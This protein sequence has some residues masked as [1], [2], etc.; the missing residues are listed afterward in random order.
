M[1]VCDPSISA[2]WVPQRNPKNLTFNN[3][4]SNARGDQWFNFPLMCGDYRLVNSLASMI[5]QESRTPQASD[6]PTIATGAC[7]GAGHHF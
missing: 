7:R 1:P 4:Y 5:F 6:I 2:L 3:V